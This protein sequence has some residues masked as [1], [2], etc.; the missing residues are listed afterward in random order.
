MEEPA[1]KIHKPYRIAAAAAAVALALAPGLA[2]AQPRAASTMDP[3]R[4]QNGVA[5]L[6]GGTGADERARMVAAA[7]DY[8]LHLAFSEHQDERYASGVDV[9]VHDIAGKQWFSLANAGPMLWLKLPAGTYVV[10]TTLDGKLKKHVVT[11]GAERDA[12]EHVLW[13]FQPRA[14]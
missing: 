11:V 10:D 6:N 5:Y 13:Q 12:Q 1:M 14:G 9:V 2:A 4:I 7:G 3:V 8:N